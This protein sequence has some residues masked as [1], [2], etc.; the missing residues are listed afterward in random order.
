[1]SSKKEEQK[2]CD[3]NLLKLEEKLREYEQEIALYKSILELTDEAIY[4][5]DLE[6]RLLYLN[7]AGEKIEGQT[8]DKLIGKTEKEIWGSNTV[9]SLLKSGVVRENER[10]QYENPEGNKVSIIHSQY[11]FVYKGKKMGVFTITKDVTMIESLVMRYYKI[12]ELLRDMKR[13]TI[14]SNGTRFTLED[15]IGESPEIKECVK[16]AYK[17]ARHM[18]SV[19]LYG[20]TGT[21]KEIFAQGIHNASASKE[22]PFIGLNCSAIPVT[23]LES[24]LFG[25]TK[26]PLPALWRRQACLNKRGRERFIWM[27][28]IPCPLICRQN[29]SGFCRRKGTEE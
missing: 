18:T 9:P 15:I 12:Q 5:Y 14:P 27:R 1:L 29:C 26:G 19:L 2:L 11:P 28:L 6:G 25:T 13:T 22:E 3:E 10:M 17:V 4:T 8:R 24:L 20:E 21:G 7:P 16:N 23:L